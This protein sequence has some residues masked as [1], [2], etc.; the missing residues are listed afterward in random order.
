VFQAQM[1]K[2]GATALD[3]AAATAS[4]ADQI[5]ALVAAA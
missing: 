2:L 4:L 1:L 3:G 5:L